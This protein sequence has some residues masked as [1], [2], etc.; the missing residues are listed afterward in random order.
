MKIP[1]PFESLLVFGFLSVML[2]AGIALRARVPVLQRFLFPSCLIGGVLGLIL[3]STGIV[4]VET[5]LLETFAFHFFNISFI[6]VGLTPGNRGENHGK[7]KSLLRGPLWMAL[8]EGVTLPLQAVVGGFLTILFCYLGMELFSTFGFFVPLGFTEGPG[9]AL[10]IGKVW[11]GLGFQHAATIGLT[12]AAIGFFFAFFVGVP[13]VNWGIRK[14]L[15]VRG[16][17]ELPAD[18]LRGIVP[19]GG[20]KESAGSLTMHSGNVDTIA[21]QS[22]LIGLVYLLTYGFVYTV[23]RVLPADAGSILWGFFFFFGMFIGLIVRWIMEKLGIGHMLDPG[24]QRRITGWSVD[25]LI[26]STVAAIQVVVVWQFILPITIM[27]LLSGILTTLGIVYLGRRLDDLNLERMVAIYGT[28]TGTVSSGLLLLRIVDPEFKT[29]VAIEI[30]LMNVIVMP[31]IVGCMVL[32]NAPLWWHWSV[33]LTSII[34][35]AILA[36]CL[37]LIKVLGFW[38]PRKF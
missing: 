6:S 7:G 14:G 1:F 32:V 18:L 21:F 17:V 26:V 35:A 33:A 34:F 29:P 27:S 12:F 31:I 22:A 5:S 15:A 8:I 19:P 36:S 23:A 13:L 37:L 10:S 30:G 9:Q 20:D 3:V 28:C 11:E 2:L 38:G 4:K 16:K 24:V 25:F